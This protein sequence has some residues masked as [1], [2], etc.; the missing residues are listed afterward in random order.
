[1]TQDLPDDLFRQG[2]EEGPEEARREPERSHAP[3]RSSVKT[4]P[5]GQ[6]GISLRMLA[7]ILVLAVLLAFAV[8]RLF[9]FRGNQ[10][11]MVTVSPAPLPTATTSA[12]PST[13]GVPYSD[14][15]VVAN[16][17]AAEGQCLEGGTR[18][19]PAMLIDDDSGTLWRCNGEG[20]GE[21]VTFTFSGR[22]P[23]VGVRVVNGNTAWSDRYLTERRILSIRWEF[24]DGSFFVQG[25]AANNRNPQEVRFPPLA[26][27]G[28][29]MTVLD[30]TAPGDGEANADAVSLSSVEFL[31]PA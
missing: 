19:T 26:A 28:V 3:E 24:D 11:P 17:L 6:D 31:T 1:M 30:A 23:L 18:D 9:F 7:G 8:G 21:Q 29:T 15:V 5:L 27:T 10:D 25:L 20:V 13:A 12:P 22:R 14:A 4:V 16:V 2:A